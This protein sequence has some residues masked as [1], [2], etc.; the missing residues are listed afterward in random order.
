MYTQ[1]HTCT[2]VWKSL[3]HDVPLESSDPPSPWPHPRSHFIR[4][5]TDCFFLW[6]L[7]ARHSTALV[8]RQRRT[9]VHPGQPQARSGRLPRL[10]FRSKLRAPPLRLRGSVPALP[11]RAMRL[12]FTVILLEAADRTWPNILALSHP[13]LP[14]KREVCREASTRVG[15]ESGKHARCLQIHP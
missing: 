1:V 10:S 15:R 8:H 12:S 13:H 9:P 6:A 7:G 5:T 3:G 2:R 4:E 14:A 11:R